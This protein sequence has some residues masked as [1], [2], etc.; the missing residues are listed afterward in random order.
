MLRH[1]PRATP[2]DTLF[3]YTTLFR[4]ISTV[5]V[6]QNLLSLDHHVLA[7]L[8]VD[9]AGA[10][11]GDVLAADHDGAVLLHGDAG[12]TRGQADGV[13]GVEDKV[14]AN[15]QAVVLL[16]VS[17]AV[18]GHVTGV[19]LADPDSTSVVWGQRV[20]VS[21]EYGGSGDLRK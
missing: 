9:G 6:L 1:P 8:D 2:T 11:D 4:S 7:R 14:L 18:L 15:V 10:V 19:V 17:G 16:D 3:P 12:R 13:T 5:L 21:V 20:S